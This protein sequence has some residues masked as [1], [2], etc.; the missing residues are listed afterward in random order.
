V[1]AAAA[2]AN[3]NFFIFS[4]AFNPALD[5]EPTHRRLQEISWREFCRDSADTI[6][7]LALCQAPCNKTRCMKVISDLRLSGS[8]LPDLARIN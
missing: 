5:L 2:V 7:T 8:M 6:S 1:A 3:P 4:S